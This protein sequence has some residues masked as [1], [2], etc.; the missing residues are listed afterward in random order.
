MRFRASSSTVKFTDLMDPRLA[1]NF[2]MFLCW[3]IRSQAHS[4]SAISTLYSAYI[5]RLH[6]ITM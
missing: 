3:G 1:R 6:P 4:D 5:L 2:L